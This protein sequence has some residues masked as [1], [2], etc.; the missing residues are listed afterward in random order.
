M[1]VMCGYG[2]GFASAMTVEGVHVLLQT[3][4]AW[5]VVIASCHGYAVECVLMPLWC[6]GSVVLK[7]R[8]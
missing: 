4:H 7:S 3:L 1:C 8:E 2:L 5:I 6:G